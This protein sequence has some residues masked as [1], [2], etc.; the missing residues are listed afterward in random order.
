[1][2]MP[3]LFHSKKRKEE[4]E[5]CRRQQEDEKKEQV[6]RENR[7]LI[8][9]Q[10]KDELWFSMQNQGEPLTR[11]VCFADQKRIW[12]LSRIEQL[13][14]GLSWR[15]PKLVGHAYD[16]FIKVMS[17]LAWICDAEFMKSIVWDLWEDFGVLFL[18]HKDSKG[19]HDRT[20]GDLPFKDTSFLPNHQLRVYFQTEQ[21][22]F[23]PI[24]ILDYDP[25]DDKDFVEYTSQDRLPFIDTTFIAEGGSGTVYRETIPPDYFGYKNGNYNKTVM[26]KSGSEQLNADFSAAHSCSPEIYPSHEET[27]FSDGT[28]KPQGIQAMSGAQRKYNAEL[29][30]FSPRRKFHDHI[31]IGRLGPL[32]LL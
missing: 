1:M 24:Y 13:A 2:A 6:A 23:N 10:V 11:F 27:E 20:D 26:C 16:H 29:H 17:I 15:D 28:E 3:S 25:D 5:A 12:N 21:Y 22:I 7:S 31:A 4:K 9:R 30:R 8:T 19:R 32:G 18:E 14:E